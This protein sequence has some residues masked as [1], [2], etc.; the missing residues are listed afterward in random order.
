[1]SKT[2]T[3]TT[4]EAVRPTIKILNERFDLAGTLCVL[5]KVHGYGQ[6]ARQRLV[7]NH[8]EEIFSY[9]AVP[10]KYPAEPAEPLLGFRDEIAYF[11]GQ[12]QQAQHHRHGGRLMQFEKSAKD[13]EWERF[14]AAWPFVS[15][16]LMARRREVERLFDPGAIHYHSGFDPSIGVVLSYDERVELRDRFVSGDWGIVGK[17]EPARLDDE[18]AAWMVGLQDQPFRN[19]Y[20]IRRG[21]GLVRAAYPLVGSLKAGMVTNVVSCLVP[22]RETV[23]LMRTCHGNQVI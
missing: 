11:M 1:M 4:A 22:G 12:F 6:V 17:H 19:S 10:D 8:G 16:D 20:A 18:V 5:A 7:T 14:R 21:A 2:E 15:E 9:H 3:A 13:V 23:T